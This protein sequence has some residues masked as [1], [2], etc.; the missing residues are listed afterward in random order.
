MDYSPRGHKDS[1]MTDQMSTPEQTHTHKHILSH[2][3]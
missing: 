2:E 1:D 3:V